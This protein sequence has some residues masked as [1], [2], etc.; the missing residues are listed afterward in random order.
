MNIKDLIVILLI[1]SI[2]FWAIFHQMASK[3][4]NSNEILK[5][6]IFGIDIY[7]N[8]SMDISNIELVITAVIM[9]NVIDF[10]S[11]NS[12]EKF[13]K[14]RSFLI[15][16]NINLKTSICIIDHHKKLWYYIKVSMFFMILIIIF[17]ITFW[18]Y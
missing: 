2:I 7:K 13:F 18:N 16:S 8:K 4:I 9:I 3:Y 11:R 17:T 5:K 1:L 12:L 10:F 14:K 6:K 15:F